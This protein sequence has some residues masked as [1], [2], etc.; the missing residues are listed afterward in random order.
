MRHAARQGFA[1]GD[2]HLGRAV[3]VQ[4]SQQGDSDAADVGAAFGGADQK[5]LRGGNRLQQTVSA[6]MLSCGVLLL[7]QLL[8]VRSVFDPGAF[9]VA[10]AVRGGNL[11]AVNDAQFVRV[12]QHG[13]CASRMVMRYRVIIQVKANIGR[14][15]D[16][17]FYP[18][19][20]RQRIVRQLQQP[21]RFVGKNR[22]DSAVGLA[23]AAAGRPPCRCTM[24]LP[25]G[26]DHRGR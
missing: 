2:R 19:V 6:T 17:D 23:R 4:Q 1:H 18:L 26:S 20:Q 3:L 21:R 11:R 7:S 8:D 16:L 14:F 9:V 22:P 5:I 13:Q 10:A 12:G 25:A 15:A 24:P